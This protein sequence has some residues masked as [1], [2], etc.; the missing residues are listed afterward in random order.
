MTNA[1]KELCAQAVQMLR[2]SGLEYPAFLLARAWHDENE[3]CKKRRKKT[4]DDTDETDLTGPKSRGKSSGERT[5]GQAAR[6][7]TETQ[8]REGDREEGDR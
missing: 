5:R 8:G 2:D 7:R 4:L 1:E 3:R 6:G